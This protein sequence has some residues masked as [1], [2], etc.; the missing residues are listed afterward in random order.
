MRHLIPKMFVLLSM[1]AGVM[2]AVAATPVVVELFTSQGCSSCPPADAL[3]G[4][5]ARKP[6]VIAFAWHVDYWDGL[7]W[8][9]RFALAEAVRRQRGYVKRM[10]RAGPFTPQAVVG[11]DTSLIGSDRNAM[12]RALAEKRDA[13]A[14][15]LSRTAD[16]VRVDF[17]ERWNGSLDVY[18]VSYLASA[19][20][21]VGRGENAHRSLKEFNIVRSFE[22]LG[23]WNG[24]PQQMSVALEKIPRDATSLAVLMQRPGQGAIAGA[25]SIQLR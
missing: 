1:F 18:V 13:I 12:A 16:A 25:A 3:L 8:K 17:P 10:S 6:G 9:D 22:R 14:V 21:D 20:T 4:E 5:I 24:T 23:A 2:P 15:R 7:G 19:T 11:G